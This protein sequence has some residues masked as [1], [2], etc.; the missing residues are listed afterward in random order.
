M[1]LIIHQ[2]RNLAE[3]ECRKLQ[4]KMYV[5]FKIW[6]L[7]EQTMDENIKNLELK[8]YYSEMQLMKEPVN[9]SRQALIG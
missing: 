8:S 5:F 9:Q 4:A 2:K 3:Q 1:L 7:S 6:Q